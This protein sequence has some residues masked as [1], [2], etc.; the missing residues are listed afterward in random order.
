MCGL[1]TETWRESYLA[2]AVSHVCIRH[3]VSASGY[4]STK[5]TVQKSYILCLLCSL[6]PESW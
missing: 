4:S 3:A 2:S 1:P 6:S 5:D